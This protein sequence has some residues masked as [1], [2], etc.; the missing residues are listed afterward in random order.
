MEKKQNVFLTYGL[1]SGIVS[2]L[3]ALMLYLGGTEWFL[4]PVAYLGFAIPIVFAVI[5]AVKH[6]RNNGGYMSFGEA[7]KGVF[8]VFVIGSL[9]STAFNYIMFNFVDVPF[10][11]ALTQASAEK[12]SEFMEKFGASQEDI[13]KMVENSF[14]GNPYSLGKMF[15]GF[16]FGCIIWFIIALIIAAIVKKKRPEF[17]EAS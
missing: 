16:V 7:L 3:F 6:K 1:I 4:H 9:L 15:F 11:Q 5:A 17:P 13:D 10:A 2:I 14:K 8:L 12:T